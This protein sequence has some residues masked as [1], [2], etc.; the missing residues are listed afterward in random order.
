[1]KK[2]RRSE[3]KPHKAKLKREGQRGT[4]AWPPLEGEKFVVKLRLRT[5]DW[6]SQ[7]E[8]CRKDEQ[9]SGLLV[10]FGDF[11]SLGCFTYPTIP[12]KTLSSLHALR[13]IR[14]EWALS[15]AM[16]DANSSLARNSLEKVYSFLGQNQRT[17]LRVATNPSY[18]PKKKKLCIL[19]LFGS[20]RT[21][22][23]L[24]FACRF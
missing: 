17:S 15:G 18:I 19:Y 21:N 8:K 5:D 13:L 3:T 9:R 24:K 6:A 10:R 7:R 20:A 12:S 11:T 4:S 16:L 22:G 23:D 2:K 1:M 14:K